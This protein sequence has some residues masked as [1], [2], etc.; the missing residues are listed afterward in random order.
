M[1]D[2]MGIDVAEM[3]GIDE[4]ARDE[5]LYVATVPDKI[6]GAGVIVYQ[7]FMDQV[8]FRLGCGSRVC[9]C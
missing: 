7:E 4:F 3:L 1:V 9:R 8:A 2:M 6:S 5:M